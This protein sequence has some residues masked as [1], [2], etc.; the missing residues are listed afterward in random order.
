MGFEPTPPK[1]LVPKTSSLDHSAKPQDN[2]EVNVN[3][4]LV[5]GKIID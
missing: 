5:P 4:L 1:W 3:W 2:R